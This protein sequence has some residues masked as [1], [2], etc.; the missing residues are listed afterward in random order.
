VV[1]DIGLHLLIGEIL[2]QV[3]GHD[4]DPASMAKV[5]EITDQPKKPDIAAGTRERLGDKPINHQRSSHLPKSLPSLVSN[6][7]KSP[8]RV[9]DP[10]LS[11]TVSCAALPI[12]ERSERS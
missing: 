11:R 10:Y 8:V 3:I 4:I 5:C 2:H 1:Q 9:A 6:R 12:R 7:C